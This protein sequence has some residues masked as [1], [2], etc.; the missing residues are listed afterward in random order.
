MATTTIILSGQRLD[1]LLDSKTLLNYPLKGA[2]PSNEITFS[3]QKEWSYK[4]GPS[5]S[6]D[7]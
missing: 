1:V 2:H 3:F 7:L 4:R 6:F 5:V